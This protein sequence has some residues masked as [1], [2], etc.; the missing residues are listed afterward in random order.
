MPSTSASAPPPGA[1]P[2][3]T[4]PTTGAATG[5]TGRPSGR[6][7]RDMALSLLVLLIPIM[8]LL[9]VY[10]WL[11]GESPTVVDPSSAY[12]D[13]RASRLFP[14]AE[15]DGLSS[16]WRPVRSSFRR[17]DDGAVLR[18]GF[19]S[20][21]DGGLQLIESNRPSDILVA[22]EL[23]A[24]ARDEG[25]GHI[26]GREW[27]RYARANGERA[28]VL[29]QPDRT[30]IVVGRGELTDLVTLAGSLR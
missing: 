20:P 21:G 23:G 28:L 6:R 22:D 19:L 4:G 30:I 17:G 3:P 15:P 27:R 25:V 1:V 12:A 2:A 26:A 13:A 11:G 16:G 9:G 7:P 14:V 5:P 29:V 10:R 8:L 24:D 18:V